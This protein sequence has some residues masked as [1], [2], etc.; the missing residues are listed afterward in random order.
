MNVLQGIRSQAASAGAANP[1]AHLF[2]STYAVSRAGMPLCA[3]PTV[4][5]GID[6]VTF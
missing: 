5:V 6:F 3:S 2:A 4:D 1:E